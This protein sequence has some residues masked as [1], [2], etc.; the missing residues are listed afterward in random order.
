MVIKNNQRGLLVKHLSGDELDR[1]IADAQKA[2][3]TEWSAKELNLTR[4]S[5]RPSIKPLDSTGMKRQ[6]CQ[7]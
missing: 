4:A 6:W 7:A 5:G 3:E 1:A 2:D